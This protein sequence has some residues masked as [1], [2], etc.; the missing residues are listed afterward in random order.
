MKQNKTELIIL[1]SG[2]CIPSK[3]R[4]PAGI[5][6]KLNSE[7]LLLDSGS[8]TLDKLAL[9]GVDYREL[10]YLC[11]THTHSDHTSDLIPILQ[12]IK[13]SP[14]FKRTDSLYI[15]GPP[16]FSSFL[17]KL[18]QAYGAWVINSDYEII[19]RELNF[20]KIEFSFGKI[21][22]APMKHS[23]SC[24][25]YRIDTADNKS[26]TYSG[27]TDYCEE[28]VSL[29]K[30]SDLLILE[31]SVPDDQKM[32]GHLTPTLAAT[33]A[34]ESNCKHLILTH[35]YPVCEHVDIISICK[36]IYQGKI[37]LAYDL[38]REIL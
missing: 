23:T 8:G 16:Q 11:Y 15:L 29:A 28:I 30:N 36:K 17:D 26:I 3:K 33:I 35:F 2:T 18:A 34:A 27:D 13:V 5:I 6:V 20:E 1:G 12:A 14:Q 32:G 7:I 9:V 4:G 24:I 10:K 38:M 25:G 37:T 31:C 21:S 19:I 22:T